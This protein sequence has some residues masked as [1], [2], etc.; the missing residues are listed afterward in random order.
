M[1]VLSVYSSLHNII[2]GWITLLRYVTFSFSHS[3]TA[4]SS[5]YGI[6]FTNRLRLQ[7]NRYHSVCPSNRIQ[8]D[9]MKK[10]ME[11]ICVCVCVSLFYINLCRPLWMFQLLYASTKWLE[12]ILVRLH[13]LRWLI[14]INS[15]TVI[16]FVYHIFSSSFRLWWCSSGGLEWAFISRYMSIWVYVCLWVQVCSVSKRVLY[17]RVHMQYRIIIFNRDC[18]V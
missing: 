17:S 13:I 4:C 10:Q 18:S 9:Q 2:H 6:P 16:E 1:C 12:N 3:L 14:K 15:I 11:C 8:T 5:F 7:L